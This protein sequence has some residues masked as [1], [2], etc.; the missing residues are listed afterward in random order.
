MPFLPIVQTFGEDIHRSYTPDHFTETIQA[1]GNTLAANPEKIRQAHASREAI[2]AYMQRFFSNFDFLLTPTIATLP[3][4]T[5][6]MSPE[7]YLF[8]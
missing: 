5:T 7:G 6:R 2:A 1:K 3:W 8:P 4:D